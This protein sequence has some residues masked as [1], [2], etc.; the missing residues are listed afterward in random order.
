VNRTFTA[1]E[2]EKITGVKRTRLQQWLEKN[3]IVPSVHVAD[4]YGTRNIYS[5][6][7]VYRIYLLKTIIKTGIK[8]ALASDIVNCGLDH[9][10]SGFIFPIGKHVSISIDVEDAI[11]FVDSRIGGL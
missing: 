3:Y 10:L 5:I 6:G 7:D 8:R 11:D 2:V 4:G 9:A 1:S